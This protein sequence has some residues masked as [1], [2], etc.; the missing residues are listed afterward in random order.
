MDLFTG[1]T[2]EEFLSAGANVTG[3]RKTR[4]KVAKKIKIGDY[5]LC[6]LTGI[7]RFIG[8]LKV[9][10]DMFVN[11]TPIW[12]DEEF[13]IRFNV[14]LIYKLEPIAAVPVKS[15]D[16]Q[17]SIFQN[18]KSPN[19]WTGFFR[20]SPAEF[21]NKDGEIIVD[22]IKNTIVSPTNREF[23][24]RK[25]KR[26]PKKYV[27]SIGIVTVPEESIDKQRTDDINFE[28]SKT[29]HEEIQWLLLNLGSNLGL[30]VW[31]SRNDKNKTHQGV[32]FKNIPNSKEEL[33][34]QFDD[35]TNKTIEMIDVLWLRGDAIIAAFE[36]EHTTS[37]YSGLL[38]MSDLI[39]MQ[40]NIKID[41]YIVAPDERRDKVF[42]E[43]NRPTFASLNPSLPRIC[44]FIPYS[45]LRDEIE[46][47]GNRVQYMKPEFIEEIAESCETDEA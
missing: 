22:T 2:W 27:S 45:K 38:R 11:E 29:T 35:A 5:F 37:V 14:E 23:D 18:L 24:E 40:P 12:A 16:K 20:G 3:F 46:Q 31:V 13:P 47:I 15:M 9:T 43:I 42:E 44:R 28:E 34:R 19:A 1:K 17:L 10:S 36:V 8:V 21:S 25:Y 7:S 39:S 30:D 33:P 26:S 4:Q 6:Y 41:L 32:A